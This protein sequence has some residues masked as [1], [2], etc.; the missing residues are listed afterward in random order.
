MPESVVRLGHISRISISEH[1]VGDCGWRIFRSSKEACEMV[2]RS[3]AINI[4]RRLPSQGW[5]IYLV[6]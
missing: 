3:E 6:E 4:R 1:W 5:A 2:L